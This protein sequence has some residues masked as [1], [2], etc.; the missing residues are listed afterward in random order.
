M[1][2]AI[3]LVGR[4]VAATLAV[5]GRVYLGPIIHLAAAIIVVIIVPSVLLRVVGILVLVVAV[6][7]PAVLIVC[8]VVVGDIVAST[9]T[10]RGKTKL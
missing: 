5:E 3:K 6:V 9:R 7:I 4:V 1:R 10:V 8:V 2:V